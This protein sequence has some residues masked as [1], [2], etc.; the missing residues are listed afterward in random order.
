MRLTY[1]DK[2]LLSIAKDGSVCIWN[3]TN[4]EGKTVEMKKEFSYSKEIL[5]SRNE[6]E[7]KILTIKDQQIRLNELET[8]H[9]Y[10]TRKM[11]SGYEDK[12]RGLTD[13]Y[14][15]V[16]EELKVKNEVIINLV[17][18]ERK[19]KSFWDGALISLFVFKEFRS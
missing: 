15:T 5:I 3:L 14:R 9:A 18:G 8:E 4:T 2:V 13:G 17:I 12:I 16:V 19:K 11:E 10:N 1:D 7:E 6:L